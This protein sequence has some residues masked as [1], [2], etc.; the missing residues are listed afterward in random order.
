MLDVPIFSSSALMV[1]S[2]SLTSQV[3]PTI[4]GSGLCTGFDKNL[5]SYRIRREVANALVDDWILYNHF[6]S[7]I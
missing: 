5:T 6:D 4:H 7:G 2:I 1:F 3:E